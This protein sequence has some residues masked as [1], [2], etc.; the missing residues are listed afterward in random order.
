MHFGTFSVFDRYEEMPSKATVFEDVL[1]Q[2]EL[3]EALGFTR[4]WVAEHH[5][6]ELGTLPSPA[7]FLA[8]AAART[9]RIEIGP[10]ISILSMHDPRR[11]AEDYAVVDMLSGG[12]LNFGTGSGYIAQ[13][14][15]AFGLHLDANQRRIRYDEG[16]DA[17]R[18]LW[19]QDVASFQGQTWQF[20]NLRLNVK[21]VQRP[22]PRIWVGVRR[23]EAAFHVAKKGLGL[24]ISPYASAFSKE[25]FLGNLRLYR[26]TWGETHGSLEGMNLTVECHTHVAATDAQARASIV[27]WFKRYSDSRAAGQQAHRDFDQFWAEGLLL[28]GS[29]QR[30]VDTIAAFREVGANELNCFFNLGGMDHSLVCDVMSRFAEDVMPHFLPGTVQR[31]AAE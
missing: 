4:A 5:F 27:P 29:T 16:L 6:V 22:H 7:V 25:E 28:F 23:K 31:M 15:E 1:R 26:D 10:C 9:T 12:R 18:A 24:M 30:V 14:F 17:V 13:E 3:S 2:I 19:T 21:P 20:E 11:I 8:A